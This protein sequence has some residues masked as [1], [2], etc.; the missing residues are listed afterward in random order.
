[1]LCIFNLNIS[2]KINWNF[3]LNEFQFIEMNINVKMIL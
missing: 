2:F 1:M 3:K